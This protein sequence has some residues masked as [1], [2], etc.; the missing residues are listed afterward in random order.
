M[1]LHTQYHFHE[2]VLSA[3]ILIEIESIVY[4]MEIAKCYK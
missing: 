3:E 4:D 2:L 1:S